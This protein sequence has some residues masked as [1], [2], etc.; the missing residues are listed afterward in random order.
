[1]TCDPSCGTS[2]APSTSTCTS[3]RVVSSHRMDHTSSVWRRGQRVQKV[4]AHRC[5]QCSN[6]QR[7]RLVKITRRKGAGTKWINIHENQ[8]VYHPIHPANRKTT[9]QHTH[10]D[11]PTHLSPAQ[12]YT[13]SSSPICR[14][15]IYHQPN[16]KQSTR[17]QPIYQMN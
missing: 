1:M 17:H 2:T 16:H 4:C 14:P 6:D 12:P 7:S 5:V 13:I 15:P 10:R 8:P 3:S 11:R 9:N